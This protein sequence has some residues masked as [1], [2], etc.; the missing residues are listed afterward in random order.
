MSYIEWLRERIGRQK[1]LIVYGTLILRNERQGVLLQRR[2]DNGLWGLPGGILEP[3]EDILACAR[4]ELCEETGLQAGELRLTGV[5]SDPRY[6]VVYP[7]GDQVQQYTV[8]FEGQLSGGQM[9]SDPE[10]TNALAF[11]DLAEIPR[12]QMANFYLDMLRDAESGG[13]PAYSPPY[14]GPQLVDVIGQLRPL[15]GHAL[16]VGAGAMAAVQRSDGR[17]LVARRT[18]D[19]EWSLPGGFTHLGENV[20]HTAL[21]EV[22]E[23]TGLEIELERLLGVFSPAE[24]WLYPNGDRAQAVVSLFLARPLGGELRPDGVE[25]S[26]VDWITPEELL[27]LST[28]PVLGRLNRAVVDCLEQGVF[29]IS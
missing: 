28:H 20:A 6:D 4:R 24:P 18:D 16:F 12:D 11:C 22:R 26:Q 15:I 19:G 2:A 8:C 21:R 27:A 7:N 23:E 17:L 25:S 14:A 9:H 13:P 10:E 29:V 3:G 5:Y 1:T